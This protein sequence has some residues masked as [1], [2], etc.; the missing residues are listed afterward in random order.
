MHIAFWILFLKLRVCPC[1]YSLRNGPLLSCGRITISEV[2][3]LL[4]NTEVCPSRVLL[5][6]Y[7]QGCSD[8]F[9]CV[10]FSVCVVASSGLTP[11]AG[12]TSQD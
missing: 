1:F 12:M 10:L 6:I 4:L 9:L 2:V 5:L 3:S 7:R 8:L 11:R